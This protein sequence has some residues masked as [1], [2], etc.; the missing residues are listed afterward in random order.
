MGTRA[1]ARAL[2]VALQDDIDLAEIIRSADDTAFVAVIASQRSQK[3]LS[4]LVMHDVVYVADRALWESVGDI[5]RRAIVKGSID[6]NFLAGSIVEIFSP[7][8]GSAGNCRDVQGTRAASD[9]VAYVESAL[10]GAKRDDRSR[11]RGHDAV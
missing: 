1:T 8:N 6:V 7:E 11:N 10:V 3:T 5:P 2:L 9:F 4:P